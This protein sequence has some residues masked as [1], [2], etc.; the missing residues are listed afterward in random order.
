MDRTHDANAAPDAPIVVGVDGSPDSVRALRFAVGEAE[1]AHAEVWLVNAIHEAVPFA[2]MWPMLTSERLTGVGRELLAD[3]TVVAE[4]LAKGQVKY[5]QL[6]SLGSPVQVLVSASEEARL[7]VLG[8]RAVGVVKRIVTGSTAL[9]VVARAHCPVVSVPH[10]WDHESRHDRLVAAIDGSMASS[11]VLAC[12]FVEARAR[13]ARLDVVHCWRLDPYYSYLVD[14]W[15]V[16]EE[17]NKQ[18]RG[19]ITELVEEWSARFPDVQVTTRMEYS[20]IADALVRCSQDADVL[21]IGRHGHGRLGAQISMTNPGSIT[22]ALLHHAHCPLEVVPVG[23][24]ASAAAQ[25]SE[26]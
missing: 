26:I 8:H 24:S 20:E 10:E 15:S 19:R 11:S 5:R 22:R 23:L 18:T 21:Y 12:A 16:R 7:L 14:E 4:D 13:S 3:V 2:P 1:R 6:T 25:A 17:W 9:G